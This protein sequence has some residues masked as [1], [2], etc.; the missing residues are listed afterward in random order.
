MNRRTTLS[1]TT[2]TLLSMAV[3]LTTA[4][5]Q[6]G[7]AQTNQPSR[8]W[9]FNVAKSQFNP[10]PAPRSSTVTFEAAGQGFAATDA[11][12]DVLGNSTKTVTNISLDPTPDRQ[13]KDI[14][15]HIRSWFK[16]VHRA[17]LAQG[18]RAQSKRLAY[19]MSEMEVGDSGTYAEYVP[20][21]QSATI[22]GPNII[23]AA[24]PVTLFRVVIIVRGISSD[25]N[26]TFAV[27]PEYPSLEMCEAARGDLVEDF[28]HILKRRYLQPFSV[29]SK[30]ARS[31]GDAA[32]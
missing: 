1:L 16:S 28:L 25:W 24:D 19:A 9:K 11:I 21:A 15:E 17:T 23:A 32:V 14:P 4:L 10:G 18:V 31:D 5:P 2:M 22:G 30:C 8:T 7:F 29:D 13:Y 6:I 20:R 26:E 3:V 12:V 27:N